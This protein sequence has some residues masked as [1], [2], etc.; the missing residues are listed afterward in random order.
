MATKTANR[1]KKTVPATVK[2]TKLPVKLPNSRNYVYLEESEG[3]L[4]V[5][6]IG[7]SKPIEQFFAVSHLSDKRT[8]RLLRKALFDAGRRDLAAKSVPPKFVSGYQN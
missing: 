6:P 4:R 5:G 7:V 2:L 1:V 8:R 3:T